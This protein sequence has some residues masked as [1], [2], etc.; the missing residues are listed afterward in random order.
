MLQEILGHASIEQ[1]QQYG[2]PDASA[3][4]SDAEAVFARG[5]KARTG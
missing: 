1:T 4:R 5:E 2:R 3:I